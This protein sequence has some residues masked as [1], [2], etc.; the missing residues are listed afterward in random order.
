MNKIRQILN[1]YEKVQIPTNIPLSKDIKQALPHL[2]KA[3]DY[4]DELYREQQH[5][6]LPDFYNQILQNGTEEQKEFMRFFNGPWN[7]T[8]KSYFDFPD[9]KNTCNFYP[10]DITEEEFK[11]YNNPQFQDPCTVIKRNNSLQAV[12]YHEEYKEYLK[13][14]SDELKKA[15]DIIS[16]ESLKEFLKTKAASLT[17]GDYQKADAKW[18]QTDAEI[19]LV[20]G[21]YEEYEDKFMGLKTAYEAILIKVDRESSKQLQEIE[22]NVPNLAKFFPLPNNSKT[23]TPSQSPIVVG[24]Q[25]YS[26]GEAKQGV[27]PAALNLPNDPYIRQNYGL[28]QIMFYNIMQEKF[29]HCTSSILEKLVNE[30]ADFQPYFY[31]VVLHE[32]SHGLGPAYRSD[33]TSCSNAL[34]KDYAVI[35]E[36][37]ADTGSAN[38]LLKAGGEYG[39]PSFDTNALLKS[40]FAGLFRSMRFGISKA[41]GSANLIQYNWLRKNDVFSHTSKGYQLNP[42]NFPSAIESLLG[43][44]C[45]IEAGESAKEFLETYLTQPEE[46]KQT[47]EKM[48]DIPIDI[49]VEFKK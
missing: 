31:F 29:K 28:K 18:V 17:D 30:K 10:E 8:G 48:E 43:K 16:D 44:L 9:R 11:S 4:I 39:I 35:E 47:I 45:Q 15:S 32:I 25:L 49:N 21:P 41:H 34:G 46:L 37:K 22:K 36:A 2:K 38:L 14:I 26:T 5:K 20:L 33:G 40:Y 13:N 23:A 3:M 42:Q 6:D 19:D 12:P 24:N 27:M 1:Q 7:E